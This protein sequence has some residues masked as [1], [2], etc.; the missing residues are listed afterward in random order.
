MTF[1]R[2]IIA[3]TVVVRLWLK[4]FDFVFSVHEWLLNVGAAVMKKS[5]AKNLVNQSGTAKVIMETDAVVTDV[6]EQ[7]QFSVAAVLAQESH[8]L[9]ILK[10]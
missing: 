4:A 5:A 8:G 2:Q 7:G 9:Q 10:F 1:E 3:E 6:P